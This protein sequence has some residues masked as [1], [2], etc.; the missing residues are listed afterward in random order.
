[1][2]T[3]SSAWYTYQGNDTDTIL[4]SRVRIAR[5][6]LG[7]HFPAL[8]SEAQ[9][10]EVYSIIVDTFPTVPDGKRFQILRLAELDGMA[11]KIFEE[12]GML[13]AVH[14]NGASKGLVIR[15]DGVVSATIN[16]KDH[17]RLASF[18]SGFTIS[19]CFSRVY[20]V[21]H[22]LA[23]QLAFS[24]VKDY[25][26]LT[27]HIDDIG[28][29]VKMSVL[30][31]LPGFFFTE[32]I[33]AKIQELTK[34][35]FEV[36]AYYAQNSKKLLGY[37]YL[38]SSKSAAGSNPERQ[39]HHVQNTIQQ[40]I[41]EERELRNSLIDSQLWRVRD[42][43]IKAFYFAKHAF[44]LNVKD[45]TDVI[46]KIKLGINVGI[47]QGLSCEACTALL[48]QIQT[49]HLGFLLL[50]NSKDIDYNIQVDELRIE[51]IRALVVQE[52]LQHAEI[53]IA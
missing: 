5:N 9:E 28:S 8:L 39:L 33:K 7:F 46:F 18:S 27:S 38:I 26:Y 23:D 45:T 41:T 51:R 13:P 12:R 52:V 1:M 43:V 3:D 22:A 2:L 19:D 30:C 21:E 32:R 42:T 47:V 24:A 31:S 20:E 29:G 53:H 15:D 10:E 11:Q 16:I 6:I 4:S 40:L 35:N 44:L 48:Y 25:G 34:Q 17:L 49:A 50:N 14:T 37:L 36:Y